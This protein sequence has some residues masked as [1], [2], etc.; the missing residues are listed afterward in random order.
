MAHGG[1]NAADEWQG[2]GEAMKIATTHSSP[3]E[4]K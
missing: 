2:H 1:K 4:E 3:S